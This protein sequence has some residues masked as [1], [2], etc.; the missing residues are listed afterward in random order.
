MNAMKNCLIGN[1]IYSF[2]GF[3]IFNAC[4]PCYLYE[5][6]INHMGFVK[7]DEKNGTYG[8]GREDRDSDA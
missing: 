3:F 5:N 2:E 7:N 8:M 6:S 1:T 4:E